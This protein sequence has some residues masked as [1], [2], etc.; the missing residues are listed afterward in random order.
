MGFS[1]PIQLGEHSRVSSR[2]YSP[3]IDSVPLGT[4]CKR[5]SRLGLQSLFL[6]LQSRP[7]VPKLLF[8]LPL[9]PHVSSQT[10]QAAGSGTILPPLEVLQS[11]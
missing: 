3:R 1:L 5:A 10:L 4:E 9:S 8:S 2:G 6:Q 7:S 11:P